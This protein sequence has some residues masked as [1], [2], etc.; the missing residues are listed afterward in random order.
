LYYFHS[1]KDGS[2]RKTLTMGHKKKPLN[3]VVSLYQ[4]HSDLN[5]TDFSSTI[6]QTF[7]NLRFYDCLFCPT[8]FFMFYYINCSFVTLWSKNFIQIIIRTQSTGRSWKVMR[9]QLIN[10]LTSWHS[11]G[12]W[13]EI[14]TYKTW[15]LV[16][17]VVHDF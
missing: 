4:F 1:T 11:L 6:L 13:C 10:Y 3:P 9:K 12:A 5:Q 15:N 17:V 2:V 16:V 14:F 7:N 8:S